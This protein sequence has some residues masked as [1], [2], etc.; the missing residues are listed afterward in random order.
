MESEESYSRTTSVHNVGSMFVARIRSAGSL[1]W[2]LIFRG[3]LGAVAFEISRNVKRMVD[4]KPCAGR[5]VSQ[6]LAP[7]AAFLDSRF[8]SRGQSGHNDP[9]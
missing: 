1:T 4:M 5:V 6:K 7:L 8:A 2:L 9:L 3:C